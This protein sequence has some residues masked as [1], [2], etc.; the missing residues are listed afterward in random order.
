MAAGVAAFAVWTCSTRPPWACPRRPPRSR[1]SGYSRHTGRVSGRSCHL[2]RGGAG[3]H[4]GPGARR[5]GPPHWLA[6]PRISPAGPG[7]GGGSGRCC[8]CAGHR[9]WLDVRI[10][11]ALA[12]VALAL[13]GV[14]LVSTPGTRSAPTSQ[15]RSQREPCSLP[16]GWTRWSSS[17]RAPSGS[18]RCSCTGGAR[19]TPTTSTCPPGWWLTTTSPYA[20]PCSAIRCSRP[21]TE[22]ASPSARS[23]ASSGR[24][25]ACCTCRPRPWPTWSWHRSSRSPQSGCS[26]NSRGYGY[27]LSR[28]SFPRLVFF[29]LVGEAVP[30]A[31]TRSTASGKGKGRPS[32]SCSR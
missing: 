16:A 27:P 31:A 18:G 22:A 32:R 7:G 4:R 1:W 11:W 8:R 3:R 28:P 17:P 13:I 12:I 29:V 25:H 9:K 20:T 15:R 6:D 30:T 24:S 23:R 19:T 10:G 26:A 21:P 2:S 14:G 5:H